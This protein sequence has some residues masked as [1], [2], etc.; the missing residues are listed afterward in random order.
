MNIL[1]TGASR[2]LGRAIALALANEITDSMFFI[3]YRT[4][5]QKA[6]Q[7]AEEIRNRHNRCISLQLDVTDRERLKE[8]VAIIISSYEKIDVLINN[9]GINMDR[10]LKKMSDEQWD[11]VIEVNLTG[12]ANVTRAFLPYI[13][14]G[15]CIINI[16]SIIGITGN[17]GQTNYA[18]SKAGV[19]ALSKSLAKE[20]AR[21]K[22]RVNVI[23]AGFMETDM[24]AAIPEKIRRTIE[25]KILLKRF[26]KPEEVASFIAWLVLK[27]T[28][29]TG[30]VY[31][32]DGGLLP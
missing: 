20:V 28:Y 9:A 18:A 25:E 29:C 22:I 21:N 1:I 12:V 15:G 7:V 2:G 3:T 11:K 8:V 13:N 16:S 30:Q 32:I 26:A 14:D 27:G 6:K 24:T 4:N 10:T 31:I 5:K 17:F 19:I 23:A